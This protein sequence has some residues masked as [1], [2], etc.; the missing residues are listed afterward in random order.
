MVFVLILCLCVMDLVEK[1]FV[2]LCEIRFDGKNVQFDGVTVL[3]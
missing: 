3:I 2:E 1:D